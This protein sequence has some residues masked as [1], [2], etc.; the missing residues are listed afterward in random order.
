[1]PPQEVPEMV[2][3]YKTEHWKFLITCEL[4]LTEVGM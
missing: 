4:N 3:G 1:M 2:I